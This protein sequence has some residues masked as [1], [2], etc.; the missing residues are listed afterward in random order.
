MRDTFLKNDPACVYLGLPD[1]PHHLILNAFY[2]RVKKGMTLIAVEEK[3]CIVGA[4]IN[5]AVSSWD[6]IKDVQMADC[7]LPHPEKELVKFHAHISMAPQLWDKYCVSSIFDCTYVAVDP[8]WQKL[9]IARR[10]IEKSW[11]L[12]RDCGFDIF[13]ID[14]TSRYIFLPEITFYFSYSNN[15]SQISS[16]KAILK[17]RKCYIAA[18]Y[19]EKS[20]CSTMGQPSYMFN[21]II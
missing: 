10:L 16:K 12:A 1:P 21:C 7:Y 2:E 3:H 15:I 18:S 14:C 17:L 9:G 20:G 13:R 5:C 19:T 6:P 8:E 11:Y 4:S